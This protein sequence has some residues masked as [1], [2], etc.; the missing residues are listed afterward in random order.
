MKNAEEFLKGNN[1][2]YELYEHPAVFTCE[3][4]EKHCLDIPGVASKNLFLRDDKKERYF[5][6]ILSS[7]KRAD[8]K[9]LAQHFQVKRLSFG[10]A[11]ELKAKLGLEPGSVSIFGL[12]NDLEAKVELFMDRAFYESGSVHFHPNRNTASVVLS[13][14]MLEK[15]LGLIDHE[16]KVIDFD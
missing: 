15:F 8:L 14:E 11:D 13:H 16:V 10:N 12:L 2:E 5:L 1:I 4:A 9:K 3:E 6:F 7:E